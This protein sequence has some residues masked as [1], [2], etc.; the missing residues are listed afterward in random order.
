MDDAVQSPRISV[1]IATFNRHEKLFALLD[2]LEA[3]SLA[4]DQFE[5]RVVDDGSSVPVT[6]S[7]RSYALF[8]ER[9]PNRGAAAARNKGASSARGDILVFVDDDMRLPRE[10]LERHLHAHTRTDR[11]V[12]LGRIERDPN[13][14]MPLFE[15]W[16][17]EMLDRMAA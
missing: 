16:H 3:Q 17:A 11:A 2:D 12:V 15:R 9:Q 5:V 1:V 8:V 6:V 14:R 13:L 4:M 10:F 7:P